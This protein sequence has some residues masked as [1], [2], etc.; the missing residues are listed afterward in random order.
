MSKLQI[1]NRQGIGGAN[2][3]HG[4]LS[5]KARLFLPR[6]FPPHRRIRHNRITLEHQEIGDDS[7]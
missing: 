2:Q 1:I 7:P 4:P 6:N 5:L 3:G